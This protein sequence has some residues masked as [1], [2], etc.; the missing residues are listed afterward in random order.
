MR[1]ILF[2]LS[3]AIV[4]LRAPGLGRRIF[5]GLMIFC[6]AIFSVTE[7]FAQH[8][9]PYW[10]AQ[11]KCAVGC[12]PCGGG[13]RNAGPQPYVAPQPSPAEIAAQRANAITAEG[14]RA[15]KVG[16]WTLAVSLYEQALRLRPNNRVIMDNLGH[17][18]AAV[19]DTK[20]LEAEKAG[21]WALAIRYFEQALKATP[22]DRVLRTVA[23]HAQQQYRDCTRSPAVGGKAG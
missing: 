17:A 7:G 11:Y 23:D 14:V 4:A 12:G 6:F 19:F 16:N 20:G 10:T 9:Q 8:C 13:S 3:M 2:I 1:E 21:N 5:L 15:E 18:R 22:K